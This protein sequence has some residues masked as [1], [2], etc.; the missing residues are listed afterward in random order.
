[1]KDFSNQSFKYS[2]KKYI[3][4]ASL[5]TQNSGKREEELALDNAEISL[6]TYD[7]ALNQMYISA[8]LE[9]YDQY[10]VIDRLLEKPF[11]Y[12]QVFFN[13]LEQKF[14]G[15]VVVEKYHD[16]NKFGHIFLVQNIQILSR[17][18]SKIQY[19]FTL[20]SN[21]WF[22]C[23]SQLS[24]T[25]HDVGPQSVFDILKALIGQ[26]QLNVDSKSFDSVQTP[27]KLRYI[28]N[29]N[30]NL[31]TTSSFLLHKLYYYPQKDDA[32]KFVVY[33][34]YKDSF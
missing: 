12:C 7:N 34:E 15:G 20:V 10:G 16:T 21:N 28:T 9:Y 8:E 19:H 29:G 23:V 18:K 4:Q 6:F 24:Y 26:A 2:G 17:E 30:D 22:N 14:D 13:E 31:V 1:M 5:F 33:N 3:F 32:L 27:V 11:V 25:N